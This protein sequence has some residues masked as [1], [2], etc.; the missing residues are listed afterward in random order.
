MSLLSSKL[1]SPYDCYIKTFSYPLCSPN[2]KGAVLPLE[3]LTSDF[4]PSSFVSCHACLDYFTHHFFNIFMIV[5][6][7]RKTPINAIDNDTNLSG[8]RKIRN[9]IDS[10]PKAKIKP[11]I[12]I[13]SP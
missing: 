6:N 3:D 11:R 8:S 9:N 1:C 4:T 5:H 10:I 12:D 2:K 7:T 13:R